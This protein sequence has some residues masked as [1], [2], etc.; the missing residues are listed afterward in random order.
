M[1]NEQSAKPT[2]F[3]ARETEEIPFSVNLTENGC[4]IVTPQGAK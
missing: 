2:A 4:S 3:Y 1:D